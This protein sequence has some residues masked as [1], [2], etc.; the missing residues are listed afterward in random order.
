M[1]RCT[2]YRRNR[3][4]RG[5]KRDTPVVLDISAHSGPRVRPFRRRWSNYVVGAPSSTRGARTIH[6]ARLRMRVGEGGLPPPSSILSPH[7]RAGVWREA[8]RRSGV[9]HPRER[10]WGELTIYSSRYLLPRG[11][12]Y[13]PLPQEWPRPLPRRWRARRLQGAPCPRGARE[14]RR[15]PSR[16]A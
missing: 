16:R 13:A 15:R 8:R 9:P 10:V 2:G 5:T 4:A 3:Q 14:R 7:P 6:V 12:V 11:A 1:C